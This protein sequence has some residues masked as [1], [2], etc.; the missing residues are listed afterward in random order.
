MCQESVQCLYTTAMEAANGHL[1]IGELSRRSGVSTELLRAWER[2]YGLL[3]PTRSEGGFRLYSPQDERR[4]AVMRDHLKRGLSAAQAARMTLEEAE[5]RPDDIPALARGADGLRDA[6]NGLDETAAHAAIDTLLVELVPGDGPR[7]RDPSVPARARG[8]LGAR[9]GVGCRRAFRQQPPTGAAARPRP[10][11]GSGRRAPRTPGLCAG[12]AAR[13]S[14]HR[15]R[16]RVARARL[17]DHLPRAGHATRLAH[18]AARTLEPTAVVIAASATERIAGTEA[19][20][21]KLARIAPLWL[22]GAGADP[23]A[24]KKTGAR[25]LDADPL[26]AADLVARAQPRVR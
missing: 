23:R 10:R 9:R 24:G 12:G 5:R 14:A 25:Y 18:R 19:A 2:R 11:L 8:P 21:R 26:G 15:L 22:A 17:A 7:R 16:P 4:V 3:R 1:R 6:L 13:S 20:L